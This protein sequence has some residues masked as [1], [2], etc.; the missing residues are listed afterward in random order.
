[1]NGKQA[2]N[3]FIFA[4][5]FAYCP[6]RLC[7]W[8]TAGTHPPLTTRAI[9]LMGSGYLDISDNFQGSILGG[10]GRGIA[11][12]IE[13]DAHGSIDKNG[14]YPS[15]IWDNR[16]MVNYK[17]FHFD[18]AYYAL[19]NIAHLTQ[20]Q[21]VPAHGANIKHG[22]LNS[23]FPPWVHVDNLESLATSRVPNEGSVLDNRLMPFTYYGLLL[24]DTWNKCGES[25]AKGSGLE[26][27]I[28]SS[29]KRG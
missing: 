13:K 4:L 27:C 22:W 15:D 3:R 1:M 12:D 2:L 28:Y 26:S 8:D 6:S 29:F 23:L 25:T 5:L 16:V 10:V 21:A 14:G 11:Y 20:D 18:D 24:Q 19:G 17:T 7:A 9:E